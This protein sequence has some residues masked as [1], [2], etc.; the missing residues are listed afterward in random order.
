MTIDPQASNP[1][2]HLL[3][4]ARV[5]LPVSRPPI[6]DGAVRISGNR[7]AGVGRRGDFSARARAAVLD[8]GE[9]ALLP[10]LVNAHRRLGYTDMGGQFSPPKGF[11]GWIKL[12]TPAKSECA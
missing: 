3:V 2:S 10:G 1:S 5:V 7:I 4:R 11:T 6:P 9:G 8:L 12:I